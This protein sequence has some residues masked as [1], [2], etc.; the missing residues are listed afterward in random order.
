MISGRGRTGRFAATRRSAAAGTFSNSQVATSTAAAKRASAAASPNGAIVAAADDL[1]GR[2]I[3]LVDKDVRAVAEIG[4]GQ[5]GHAAELTAA[6]DPIVLP[7]GS[8]IGRP[9][10]RWPGFP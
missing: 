8:I 2:G 6:E 1:H 4:G 9:E 5:R 3:G 10:Y 7:G